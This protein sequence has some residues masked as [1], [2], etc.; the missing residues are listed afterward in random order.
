MIREDVQLVDARKKEDDSGIRPTSLK[1]FIGQKK[2]IENLNVYIEAAKMRKEPLDH[3]LFSGPPGLGKTTLARILAN[4][5]NGTFHQIS[6]PNLKRPGDM[7]RILTNVAEND[8]LFIDEI[9]RLSAPVEE[10]LYSAMEDNSIDITITDGMAASSIQLKIPPF[11][12]AA[13]TTRAGALSAPLRDRFGIHERLEFYTTEDLQQILKRCANIWNFNLPEAAYNMIAERSRR[14]PRIAIRLLRRVWDFILVKKS[15]EQDAIL[16]TI[17]DAFTQL[18]I[19]ELGLTSLDREFLN[20]IAKR[21]SGGPVGLK[22]ISAILSEDLITL[23]DFI[24]PYLVQIGFVK[25]TPRGR[26]LTPEA[27]SH[28]GISHSI[29]GQGELF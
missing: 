25:R 14:T 1:D 3:I 22:P 23:E 17:K 28:L 2:I 16:A 8:V 21:Y 20:I 4:V 24:E 27:Y 29:F 9:H 18:G 26:T 19:D 13:A 11:T 5:Q 6:A 10:V 15:N 7:A 12:L